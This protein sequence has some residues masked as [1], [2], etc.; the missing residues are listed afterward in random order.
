[1]HL[2]KAY[3]STSLRLLTNF[4]PWCKFLINVSAVSGHKC[5][6]NDSQNH[7]QTPHPPKNMRQRHKNWQP[8]SLQLQ[9]PEQLFDV[10][11]QKHSLQLW[12]EISLSW[13]RRPQRRQLPMHSCS[14]PTAAGGCRYTSTW[15]RCRSETT[16]YR[17]VYCDVADCHPVTHRWQLAAV[18]K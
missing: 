12:C 7:R 6:Q 10:V 9:F 18:Q 2:S 16:P 17:D 1:M 3:T 13:R 4:T 14:R 11:C 15:L 5:R 8:S